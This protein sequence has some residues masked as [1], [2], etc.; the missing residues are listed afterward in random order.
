MHVDYPF[1]LD[2]RRRTAATGEEDHLRDLIEQVLFTNPGERVQRPDFGAGVDRLVFGPASPQ[3]AS[4]AQGIVHGSL[5]Q[6]LGDR[7]QVEAVEVTSRDERLTLEV[8]Y[9]RV[10]GQQQEVAVF[11]REMTS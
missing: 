9:S 11:E 4:T 2:T 3:V 6:W 1:H 5:Q 7:I 10:Q 8:R